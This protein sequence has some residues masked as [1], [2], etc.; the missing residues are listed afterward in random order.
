MAGEGQEGSE[1]GFLLQK[2]SPSELKRQ[3]QRIETE[4]AQAVSKKQTLARTRSIFHPADESQKERT[5]PT[6]SVQWNV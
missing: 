1:S 4:H 6:S 2:I 5:L 3:L